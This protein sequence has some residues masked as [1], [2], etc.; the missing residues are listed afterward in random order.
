MKV[1]RFLINSNIYIALAAVSLALATEVQ[2]GMHPRFQIYFVVVFFA[3]LFDYNAHRFIA[4]YNK[5]EAIHM[6]KLQWAAE[7]LGIVK[8]LLIIAASGLVISL[9]F[10]SY[11]TLLVL[12]L[13]ALLSFLYSN[14]FHGVH[15][16]RFRMLSVPASKTL[17]IAFV[18]TVATVLIP[19][20][21][22]GYTGNFTSVILLFAERFFFI[23]AIAIPFDIRDMKTD[24]LKEIKSIPV[25]FGEKR[26]LLICNSVM[27]LSVAIACIHYLTA[28][29]LFILP[30]FIISAGL[31]L[32]FINSPK[33]K[34]FPLY[35]HGI[36]DGS[37]I[38]HG[39][40]ISL[41]FF[42]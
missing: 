19:L 2:L 38:L 39:L 40:L 27:S 16:K 29:M 37:I 9:V 26:A 35:Y 15:E 12:A 6:E 33:L 34:R 4:V 36:L 14:P 7:N 8:T 23:F 41:S 32:I 30:A 10:V 24:A 28:S 42:L 13:L 3:T 1:L 25:L 11:K 20:L 31:T 5:P 18:W 17:L 21:Q 22:S